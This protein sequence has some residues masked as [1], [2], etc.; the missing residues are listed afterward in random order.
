[1]YSA[2][3]GVELQSLIVKFMWQIITRRLVDSDTSLKKELNRHNLFFITI[4]I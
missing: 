2:S 1:M 4:Q 3:V